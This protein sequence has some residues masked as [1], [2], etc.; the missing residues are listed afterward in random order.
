[1]NILSYSKLCHVLDHFDLSDK[2]ILVTSKLLEPDF[3]LYN[4]VTEAGNKYGLECKDYILDDLD[5]EAHI[6]HI[7]HKITVTNWIKTKTDR[8][9]KYRLYLNGFDKFTYVFVLFKYKAN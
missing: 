1:M 8:M 3:V 9:D 5:I 4:F 2:L 7:E 6:L